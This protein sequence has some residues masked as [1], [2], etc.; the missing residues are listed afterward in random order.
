VHRWRNA[1]TQRWFQGALSTAA[2]VVLVILAA[3]IFDLP[4]RW[5]TITMSLGGIIVSAFGFRG[6][7][8]LTAPGR[9]LQQPQP[10][11][12]QQPPPPPPGDGS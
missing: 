8:V 9:E 1:L 3:V 12:P 7:W 11:T 6:M 5:V 4:S 10:P 2:I